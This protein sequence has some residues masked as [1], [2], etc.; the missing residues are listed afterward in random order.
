MRYALPLS[1]FER[2]VEGNW[3]VWKSIP[4][5]SGYIFFEDKAISVECI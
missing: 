4:G 5:T 1:S 3:K 2:P